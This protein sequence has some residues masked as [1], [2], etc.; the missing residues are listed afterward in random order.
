MAMEQEVGAEPTGL[1][2][3]NAEPADGLPTHT[4]ADGDAKMLKGRVSE[5]GPHPPLTEPQR[6]EGG[7]VN[8]AMGGASGRSTS[9][10]TRLSLPAAPPASFAAPV[11]PAA[12]CSRRLSRASIVPS[13]A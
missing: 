6:G 12:L 1:E 5:H 13:L 9:F 3:S 7:W 2:Q 8:E 11:L 4:E 10:Q